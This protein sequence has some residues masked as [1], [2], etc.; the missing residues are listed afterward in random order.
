MLTKEG[1][2]DDIY[3]QMVAGVFDR[4][5]YELGEGNKV[6]ID[7]K[8][9]KKACAKYEVDFKEFMKYAQERKKEEKV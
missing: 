6:G 2:F 9:V 7:A 1:I 4:M 5:Y 3:K 8:K